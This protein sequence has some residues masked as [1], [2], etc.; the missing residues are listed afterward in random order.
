VCFYSALE[1][2]RNGNALVGKVRI[3]AQPLVQTVKVF[4]LYEPFYRWFKPIKM[5]H[6]WKSVVYFFTTP[7]SKSSSTTVLSTLHFSSPP[8]FLRHDGFAAQ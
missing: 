3:F 4:I 5:E 1:V 2:V 6:I 7:V 8:Q